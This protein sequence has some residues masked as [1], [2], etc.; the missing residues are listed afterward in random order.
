M[1]DL[2]LN[3]DGSIFLSFVI[4]YVLFVCV[5]IQVNNTGKQRQYPQIHNTSGW[6]EY[7]EDGVFLPYNLP[8]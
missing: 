8:S 6:A 7:E 3:S 2:L 5:V 4:C 1:D